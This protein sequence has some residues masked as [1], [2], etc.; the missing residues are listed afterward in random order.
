MPEEAAPLRL[1]EFHLPASSL[2][3][4]LA[5]SPPPSGTMPFRNSR[6]FRARHPG[7]SRRLHHTSSQRRARLSHRRKKQLS[8]GFQRDAAHHACPVVLSLVLLFRCCSPDGARGTGQELS[9]SLRT[10]APWRGRE[11]WNTAP[12]LLGKAGPAG[13]TRPDTPWALKTSD[14]SVVGVPRLVFVTCL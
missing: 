7:R 6:S 8:P 2:R 14:V 1:P 13:A 9:A 5:P 12:G 3:S 11:S 4:K 10:R